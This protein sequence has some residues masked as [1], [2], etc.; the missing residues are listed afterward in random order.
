MGCEVH[1]SHSP[2]HLKINLSVYDASGWLAKVPACLRY[3]LTL[4]VW[5]P[6]GVP[7]SLVRAR[8]RKLRF[9]KVL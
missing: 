2:F 7:V 4:Q 6:K 1:S 5:F 9:T 3:Q 8:L